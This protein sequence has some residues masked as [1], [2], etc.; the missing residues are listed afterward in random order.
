MR[1]AFALLFLTCTAVP[2]STSGGPVELRTISRGAYA[3]ASPEA[4]QAVA[5]SDEAAY[6]RLW[7]ATIGGGEPPAV[8]FATE[9]VV[10]L[11]AGS[12]PTGGWSVVPRGAAVE[13]GTLV[14]DAAIQGPPPGAIVTQAFTS[15][16]AVVAVKTKAFT[17]VRWKP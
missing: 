3:A 14:I 9:S 10:F 6:R 16:Y 7:P 17:D 11:L 5:A 8:D 15:P 13:S 4:P 2:S 1:A 12:K